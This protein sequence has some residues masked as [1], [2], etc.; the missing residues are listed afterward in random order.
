MPREPLGSNGWKNRW[1]WQPI[2]RFMVHLKIL[3][4]ADRIFRRCADDPIIV[5]PQHRTG[6]HPQV[7]LIA[8]AINSPRQTLMF[9]SP[10]FG[11]GVD[12]SRDGFNTVEMIT[13]AEKYPDYHLLFTN[14]SSVYNSPMATRATIC[15]AE[16]DPSVLAAIGD[17]L[18]DDGYE[19]L[20]ATSGHDAL[21]MLSENVHILITDLWMPGMDGLALLEETKRRFPLIEIVLITGN[22]TVPSAVQAMKAGAFDYLT[23]PF[24]P[25]DLLDVVERALEHRQMREEITRW[26]DQQPETQIHDMIGRSAKMQ[27]VYETIRRVAPFKSIVLVTGESGTGKEMVVRAIHALSPRNNGPF[28]AI[29]CAAVPGNLM[30]SELFGH[31]RGSFTGA[32]AKTMGY[33]EAANHGTLFIDEVGELDL[34][35]QAKLLR[36]LETGTVSPVGSTKEKP[37]DVRVLAATNADLQKAVDEKRFRP[38]LFYRLNV[39]RIDLPAL[40][41]RMEDLSS[42]IRSLLERLC[43]EHG[44]AVPQVE[45]S[46][47]A[48]MQ[49]YNWPGNVRE[50]RNVLESILILGQKPV[51]TA[52]DLPEH[53]RRG[54]SEAIHAVD[55]DAAERATIVRAL[56]QCNHDRGK[57]A[58]LLNVSVR[59]LYRKMA[60]Y[61]MS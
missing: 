44:L 8:S 52:I 24:D 13:G 12:P 9:A 16:D 47:I 11:V 50:L 54:S 61:G 51:L 15:L 29:N 60:R 2:N 40:R 19:V 1:K 34:T 33:F 20:R 26:N 58:R 18:Q 48:A 45:E 49:R 7:A 21:L 10:F 31:E 59:T 32:S 17:V 6:S 23:K 3:V 28:V 42:L 57:A 37:V 55:L 53:I 56:D 39:V 41:Q 14:Y 43:A 25:P 22:A 38:D 35:L 30:E 46:A 5:G 4:G 36:V 27:A